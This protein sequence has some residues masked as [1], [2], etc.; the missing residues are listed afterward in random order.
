MKVVDTEVLIEGSVF[1]HGIDRGQQGSGYGADSFLGTAP[2][3]Q[4]V[5]LG[6]EIAGLGARCGPSALNQGGFQPGRSL[7]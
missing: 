3:S 2:G 6:V 7:F 4:A 1:E 5:V